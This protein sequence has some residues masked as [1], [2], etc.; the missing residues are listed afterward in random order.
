MYPDLK[1][2]LMMLNLNFLSL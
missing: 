2:M 1:E